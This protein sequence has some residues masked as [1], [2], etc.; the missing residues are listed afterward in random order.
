MWFLLA[1]IALLLWSGSDLFSKIGSRPEDKY[2]HWK[3][4]IFVG[5]VMGLH[6][7]LEILLGARISLT[8]LLRY[9]PAS[10]LYIASMVLGYVGLRY[11]ELSVSSPICNSSGA[12]AA[13]ACCF[14]LQQSLAALQWL[15]VALTA[16]G[17]VL[18][19]FAEGTESEAE[20]L[21]RR[22][23]QNIKYRISPLAILLPFLYCLL[24]AAGT[25]ADAFLLQSLNERSANVAYE[26]TFLF[27]AV[28]AWVY[29]VIIKKQA[30]SLRR[31][32]PKL[33]A[34]VFETGGQLAYVYALSANAVAAAPVISAYCMASVLWSR[35][36]LKEKLSPRHYCA[37]FITVAGIVILGLF[38]G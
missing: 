23:S 7:F 15:G 5:G 33:T 38:D 2:S 6:A 18:L 36:F 34:A 8:V 11:I 26:L 31:E 17:V 3:M 24:D 32:L 27:M 20:R 13:L 22:C 25:F 10:V 9:L 35:V 14:F 4:V 12:F 29:V 1:L 28:A 30:I 16:G 19:G 21:R 37:I